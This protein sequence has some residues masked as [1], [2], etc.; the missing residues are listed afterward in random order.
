MMIDLV[1]A[2]QRVADLVTGTTDDQLD[3]PTPC[4]QMP[5]RMLLAHLHGLAV[6]FRDA[7]RKIDGPTTSTA[8][9]PAAYVLADDWR[10]TIPAAL[11]ELA[12]AWRDSDA[13][14]GMTKA[15][16]QQM[17]AEVTGMVALDEIVLHG[18]DLA[19][20]TG[21]RYDV[22]PASLD[23]VEQFCS[24]ISDDPAERNGLFGPRVEVGSDA[25]QFD[26]VLGMAGRS[27]NWSPAVA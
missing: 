20:A 6:A 25:A 16:G 24:Q 2:T 27:P 18:W 3:A 11:R 9:D 22:D 13:W 17:P 1:P 5:V 14:Q 12:E 7:A 26:R 15:G 10:Q 21:R 23:T 19:V 4:E 8:P